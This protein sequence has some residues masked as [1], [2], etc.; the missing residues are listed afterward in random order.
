MRS[1]PDHIH[2]MFFSKDADIY[3]LH[4][5]KRVFVEEKTPWWFSIA[6]LCFSIIAIFTIRILPAF[7]GLWVESA[8]TEWP[9]LNPI[10]LQAYQF[11]GIL[12]ISLFGYGMVTLS[13]DSWSR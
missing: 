9:V 4:L 7:F 13:V 5:L 8:K 11:I 6:S 12:V 3:V 1:L 2:Y 10:L